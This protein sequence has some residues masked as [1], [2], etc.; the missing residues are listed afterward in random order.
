MN[1]GRRRKDSVRGQFRPVTEIRPSGLSTMW[2]CRHCG[3]EREKLNV[4]Q[5]GK[6]LQGCND[7]QITS[8]AI[9]Y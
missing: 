6:H 1:M 4:T 9:A 5:M 2:L 7:Y 8:S 3:N